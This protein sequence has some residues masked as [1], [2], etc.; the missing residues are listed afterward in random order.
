MKNQEIKKIQKSAREFERFR[1][2]KKLRE[3]AKCE[4]LA[5]VNSKLARGQ[6]FIVADFMEKNKNF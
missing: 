5:N 3:H 2:A 4:R 1:W 6:L